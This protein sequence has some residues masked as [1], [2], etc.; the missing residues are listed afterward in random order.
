MNFLLELDCFEGWRNSLG[1]I[2]WVCIKSVC[3][4]IDWQMES[5]DGWVFGK[6]KAFLLFLLRWLLLLRWL[7][8]LPT[9]TGKRKIVCL[10]RLRD[11]RIERGALLSSWSFRKSHSSTRSW[12]HNRHTFG[13]LP[14]RWGV[15]LF[16]RSCFE[17]VPIR[18]ESLSAN[19]TFLAVLHL[20]KLSRF[21]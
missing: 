7:Q 10:L 17:D 6:L 14:K 12:L 13:L 11:I 20:L 16:L 8:V 19:Q 2:G 5:P 4:S 1:E 9:F 3:W 18:R 21:H 15:P